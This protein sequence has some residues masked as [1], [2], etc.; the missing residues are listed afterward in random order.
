M[1]T[2]CSPTGNP[3]KNELETDQFSSEILPDRAF[4]NLNPT[5]GKMGTCVLK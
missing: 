4:L 1:P 2:S 3:T 5:D